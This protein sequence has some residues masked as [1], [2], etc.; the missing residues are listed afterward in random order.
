VFI[1]FPSCEQF[2][3]QVN[4]GLFLPFLQVFCQILFGRVGA[5]FGGFS[6]FALEDLFRGLRVFGA[7]LP[8]FKKRFVNF[9]FS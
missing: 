4:F 8:I 7:C 3:Q 2:A 6:K 1:C 9:E 5:V